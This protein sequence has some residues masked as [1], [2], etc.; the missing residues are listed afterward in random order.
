MQ[1]PHLAVRIFFASCLSSALLTSD[2]E[3]YINPSQG[4]I[5][6]HTSLCVCADLWR[7]QFLLPLVSL[8]LVVLAG[9]TGFCACLC[10]SLTP[11]L[12]IGV[13]HMLAGRS[14]VE[15]HTCC[16]TV[17][18]NILVRVHR[19]KL[20][21]LKVTLQTYLNIVLSMVCYCFCKA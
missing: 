17:Q 7:C 3:Y 13:L 8:G 10:R 5:L 16:Q 4:R 12:G 1:K 15:I 14:N 6:S 11:T 20:L 18:L 2:V 19:C 9:L 21:H